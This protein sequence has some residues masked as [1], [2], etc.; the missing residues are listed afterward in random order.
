MIGLRE[1]AFRATF[2]Y[3]HLI[4]LVRWYNIA[5]V[6]TSTDLQFNVT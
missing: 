1:A 2:P 3:L 5:R 4:R 6:V